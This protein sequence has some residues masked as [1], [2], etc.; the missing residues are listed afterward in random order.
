MTLP[1]AIAMSIA[2]W[3]VALQADLVVNDK[4][5]TSAGFGFSSA[6]AT[7]PPEAQMMDAAMSDDKPPLQL[8]ARIGTMFA[9]GTSPAMPRELFTCAPMIPATWVPCH[10]LFRTGSTP[11]QSPG[12]LGLLSQPT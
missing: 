11:R 8:I 1:F 12:S 5:M 7:R 9:I 3:N 2:A 4:L 6:P 10:E